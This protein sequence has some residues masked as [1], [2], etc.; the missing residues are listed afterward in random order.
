MQNNI[1]NADI[2]RQAADLAFGKSNDIVRLVFLEN[3]QEDKINR[4]NLNL[5]SEIKRSGNGAIEV[6][7]LNRLEIMRFLAELMEDKT[8]SA[9]S[10]AAFFAAIDDAAGKLGEREHEI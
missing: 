5:V 10:A 6:K 8:Q 4:L 9:S 2:I 7:L 3:G 1:S